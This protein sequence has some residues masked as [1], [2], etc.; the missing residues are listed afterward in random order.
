MIT[1]KINSKIDIINW[2][3]EENLYP[4]WTSICLVLILGIFVGSKL[5]NTKTE[6]QVSEEEYPFLAKRLFEKNPNYVLI[7]F[8]PLRT[9]LNQYFDNND[10]VGSLYFEYLPSDTSIRINGSKELRAASLM[11]L[12]VAMELSKAHEKRALLIWMTKLN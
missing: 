5:F 6:Q 7:N 10:L 11:K 9:S 4:I 8:S 3:N 2:S 12:P 1:L